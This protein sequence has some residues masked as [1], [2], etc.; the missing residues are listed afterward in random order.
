MIQMKILS[1]M[2]FMIV[3]THFDASHRAVS[4][5]AMSL[6]QVISGFILL[7]VTGRPAVYHPVCF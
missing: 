5:A 4:G 1:V 2:H 3:Q 6:M 7:T